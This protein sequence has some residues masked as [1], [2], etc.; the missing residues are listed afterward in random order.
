M[1]RRMNPGIILLL[2]CVCSSSLSSGWPSIVSSLAAS[3]IAAFDDDGK[4][5]PKK[6]TPPAPTPTACK[7]TVYKDADYDGHYL[8]LNNTITDLDA[9]KTGFNDD[10]SSI[11][12]EGECKTVVMYEHEDLRGAQYNVLISPE[13]ENANLN[14]FNDIASSIKIE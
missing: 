14:I 9:N 11:K 10:I 5:K 3:G 13:T 12:Y 6:E 2:L 4:K 1:S 8:E 7:V